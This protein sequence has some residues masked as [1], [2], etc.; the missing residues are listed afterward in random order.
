MRANDLRYI[1][2]QNTQY[3]TQVRKFYAHSHNRQEKR[4]I[5]SDIAFFFSTGEYGISGE[6]SRKKGNMV[7]YGPQ[8]H[9]IQK[10]KQNT[11]F[12][13]TA[14]MPDQYK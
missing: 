12:Y 10:R 8:S 1:V 9:Y 3:A 6:I 7:R 11:R 5:W 14:K 4:G 13:F 2:I